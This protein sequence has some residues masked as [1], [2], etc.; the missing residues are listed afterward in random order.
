MPA[1]KFRVTADFEP[2]KGGLTARLMDVA[3]SVEVD[4]VLFDPHNP[5]IERSDIDD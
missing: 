4:I 5:G 3:K 1:A 2:I